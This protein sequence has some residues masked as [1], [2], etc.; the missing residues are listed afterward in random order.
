MM[1]ARQFLD[2][3]EVGPSPATTHYQPKGEREANISRHLSREHCDLCGGWCCDPASHGAQKGEREANVSR[4]I[5]RE[6]ET[7]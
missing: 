7:L 4:H 5:S 1:T 6:Q 3:I 2:F